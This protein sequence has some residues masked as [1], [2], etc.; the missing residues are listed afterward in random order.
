M[1]TG[2]ILALYIT[3]GVF[4]VGLVKLMVHLT[5]SADLAVT[6][7]DLQNPTPAEMLKALVV[8]AQ[9]LYII[10]M[11]VGV[12]WP[13]SLSWPLQVVGGI[14]SS[15][16][17]S[18]I[19]FDCILKDNRGAPVAVQKLLICL[20]TPAGVLCGVLMI[21]GVMQF[22]RSRRTTRS[23]RAAHR[24]KHVGHDFASVVMC[25][26]FM[27]LPTWVNTA[28]SLF[29]CVGLDDPAS[30]PL[31]AEA[32][33][34]WWIED[35]SQLCYSRSG[36]HRGWA[37]GL[38]IPLTLLFCVALPASVFAFMWYSR[39][40]G[41]L[42]DL[43]FQQHYGFVY[44]QWK[45]KCCWWE[46]VALLQTIALVIVSTFGFVLG[47]YHQCL[48]S[49]TVLAIVGMLL[50]A[51]KPFVCPAAGRVAVL[52][53][54][55]LFFTTQA[56]LSFIP[57]ANIYPGP[58]YGNIMGAVILVAN[59]GFLAGTAWQLVKVVDWASFKRA[60]TQPACCRDNANM[61]AL[62][63]RL[64]MRPPREEKDADV[65]PA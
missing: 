3:A 28:L 36:Y 54:C 38:G 21:E 43:E 50:L 31:E 24:S 41:K 15:T 65:L 40:Q 8:H 27:F 60:V 29:T 45:D 20:F 12:P 35:M 39:K 46:S 7:T 2:T 64:G 16:S 56:A 4:M 59:V 26:V 10:S 42:A 5:T 62:P 58:V 22:L 9:W 57:S 19:G 34:S 25:I 55:V 30:P 32:V 37:L 23:S 52:S 6:R 11:M 44:R 63:G 48:L 13:P 18:S 47:G 61:S 1:A 14:W 51:V 49:S 17:G 33:G 53:V